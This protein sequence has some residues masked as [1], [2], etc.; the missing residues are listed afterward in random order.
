MSERLVFFFFFSTIGMVN[1]QTPS[2]ADS[3]WNEAEK[4]AESKEFM[5]AA[6]LYELSAEAEKK[7]RT[8][9]QEDLYYALRGASYYYNEVNLTDKAFELRKESLEQCIKVFG[10]EHENYGIE[11]SWLAFYYTKKNQ[12][13]LALKYYLEGLNNIEHANGKE[14]PDYGIVLHHLGV[15]C[16]NLGDFKQA[17]LFY[18]EAIEHAKLTLGEDHLDYG[19][20][21]NALA[22]V[23]E[24][25]GQY[26]DAM[27]LYNEAVLNA[28]KSVGKEHPEYIWRLFD[29]GRFFSVIDQYQNA[30][31][32][33]LNVYENLKKTTNEENPEYNVFLS[34][35]GELYLKMDKQDKAYGLILEALENTLKHQGKEHYS[36]VYISTILADYY[37]NTGDND[38]AFQICKELK[39]YIEQNYEKG[40]L[41]HISILD[42]L[43]TLHENIGDYNQSLLYLEESLRFQENI[44]KNC[45]DYYKI[46]QRLSLLFIKLGQNEKALSILY[47]CQDYIIKNFPDDPP[48][49]LRDIMNSIA[50]VYRN[51]GKFDEAE[52]KF[53]EVLYY[54]GNKLGEDHMDYGIALNNLG[55]FYKHTG[56][57][58]NSL[59]ALL[60]ALKNIEISVGTKHIEYGT[61]T[62]NI[63]EVYFLKGDLIKSKEYNQL[64]IENYQS[65]LPK[66][67]EFYNW[68]IVMG[69]L[70]N[71]GFGNLDLALNSYKEV[72][73]NIIN[74]LNESFNFMSENQKESFRIKSL[75]EIEIIQSFFIRNLNE[76]SYSAAIE[77]YD[78]EVSTK[79]IILE[80][81]V[82]TR[83]AIISSGD[84]TA[85]EKF[86]EWLQLRN[87]LAQ[88][89]SKPLT[90][91]RSDT[92]ELEEKS[93]KTEAE[94][95]RISAAFRKGT[96]LTNTS[97]KDVQSALQPNE[98]AV[99]FAAFN[100][101]NNRKWTDSV[102]YVALVLRKEDKHPHLI[103]LFEQKQLDS[104][105]TRNGGND[106]GFVTSLYR[107]LTQVTLESDKNIGKSLYEL[108]WKP[109]EKYVN[110][111][112]VVYFTPAGSLH[113]ISF[114]ALPIDENSVLLDQYQL[115]QLS[116]TAKLVHSHKDDV[117]TPSSMVFFG[118]IEYNA[119]QE[120]RLAQAETL[121]LKDNFSRALHQELDRGNEDWNYLP[122][123]LD[124]V[125]NIARIASDFKIPTK[126]F[127]NKEAQE[128]RVK[129]MVDNQAP[130]VLHIAT[131]GFFFPD[132]KQKKPDN[133]EI[134]P[135]NEN[136]FQT[137]NN[138]LNRSGLLFTGAN[139]TWRGG[140]LYE[141]IEDGILTANEVSHLNLDK[142]RL[143]VL[144][145]CE[146]GLGDIKGSEGV[147]G[148][149][150]A[151]KMAGVDYL[152][153]SLWKVPDKETAEFMQKFYLN[154]FS[155]E[156]I[157]KAFNDAQN[158]MKLQYPNEPYKWAAFVLVR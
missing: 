145:A 21:I 44:C 3:L 38:K 5:K 50:W 131:H 68:A 32:I 120:E 46:L 78:I 25:N 7:S 98:V 152:I 114:A 149:Q 137:Q 29:L 83:Q 60:E 122:G 79:G 43:S 99:E 84:E 146:T 10:K 126:T 97:W 49:L 19:S 2:I 45:L 86:E 132:P 48:I 26:E 53:K 100:Y 18:L 71:E 52:K 13:N 150:R 116:T 105:L 14:H 103:P 8:P 89:Y 147:F 40:H 34:D 37:E 74:V 41:N 156:S 108:I 155:G 42:R 56:Q 69:S 148:L 125:N 39:Q 136:V 94:L 47:E 36:Y 104:L 139:Y 87:I 88:Q 16:S 134:V 91:R 4:A 143:V 129:Q 6:Q 110:K 1:A 113:Q 59:Y 92:S 117:L 9:R 24:I 77:A 133:F 67:H 22:K 112:S 96:A 111:G 64:Q 157:W 102:L 11:T 119:T 128:E 20:R 124:E 58:D 35:L 72:K 90:V 151:F 62:G 17:R 85:I 138:P 127:S 28:E 81:S 51:S 15:T 55:A 154:W 121:Q 82:Q 12:L 115:R 140:Q 80:S 23:Y 73:N 109:I 61:A 76:L 75:P 63:S 106:A 57:L 142:T 33:Y 130:D 101:Y 95:S 31:T 141:G 54:I 65:Q 107:G 30:L 27:Q 144:S 158:F 135:K 123:T 118:G 66:S 153:M 70:I 93:E